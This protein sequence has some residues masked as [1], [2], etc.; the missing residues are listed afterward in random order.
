[1]RFL[2]AS[3]ARGEWPWWTP[4]VFAGWPQIADPQ[5]F[6]FSPLHV[7]L[8]V[9][10]PNPSARAID[11]VTFVHLFL[12]GLGV[13]LYFR[14]RDWHAAGAVVAAIAFAFGGAASARLQHTGQIISLAYLPLTLWMLSRALDRRDWRVG[15]FAGVLGG[16][17]ALGR[18]QVALISLYVLAGYV[19]WHWL[20]GAE[21]ESNASRQHP[22]AAAA[23]ATGLVVAAVPI[24][25][26]ALLA[27]EFEPAG[28]RLRA[29]PD[30]DRCI[31]R[32][33]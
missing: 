6:V 14:D 27:A 3:L 11:G 7:L 29:S 17:I 31:R 15:A 12:G 28:V 23:A 8:A 25:L 4:N 30:A 18:D 22:A 33:C 26:S 20:D 21:A 10:D 32:T 1:M 9:L 19:V 16:L 5:S 24:V 13:I 2:A